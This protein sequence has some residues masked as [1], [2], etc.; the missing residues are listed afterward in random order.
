VAC[1]V[2]WAAC[3]LSV[4]LAGASMLVLALDSQTVLDRMHRQDPQLAGRG[5]TDHQLLVIGYVS[6]SVV[7]A[8]ALAAGILGVLAYL[9]H[10]WAYYVLLASTAAVVVLC[11]V[12]VIGSVLVGVPLV[13]A[14]ATMV[15]LL[16]PEV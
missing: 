9:G 12:A 4:L 14:L 1:L 3:S 7:I 15:L 10:R 13:A 6:G 11:L 8:W 16:R 5:I 2:T